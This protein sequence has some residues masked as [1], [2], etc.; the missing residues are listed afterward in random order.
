MAPMTVDDWQELAQ[1]ESDG[2][3]VT[4]LWSSAA[5][6]VKLVVADGKLRSRFEFDVDGGD[7]LMAFHH[8]FPYASSRGMLAAC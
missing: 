1:R 6:R 3:D 7:A 4:L 2:I 8:P 5:E